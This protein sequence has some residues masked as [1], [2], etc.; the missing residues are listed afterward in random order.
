MPT[1]TEWGKKLEFWKKLCIIQMKQSLRPITHKFC[2]GMFDDIGIVWYH[3]LLSQRYN[4]PRHS[5]RKH[6]KYDQFE[7]D[8]KIEND[9]NDEFAPF[10]NENEFRQKYRMSRDSLSKL[11]DLI[12]E[13][14]AFNPCS[15]TRG[16]TDPKHQLM[17]LLV[18]L[19][20]EG[21]GASNPGLRS[22]F[23]KGRGTF[24]NFKKRCVDAILDCLGNQYLNWPIEGERKEISKRFRQ[25]F[26][27][28]NCVGVVD[29]TLLPLAFTPETDD[30]P[31]YHG[32]KYQYSL[33]VLVI[34]DDKRRI[35]YFLAGWP[36]KTHD[37]RVLR[38][39]RV[40]K[41]PSAF[42]RPNE[43]ILGDSAFECKWYCI[44]AF[45]KTAGFQIEQHKSRFN[46]LLSSPRV[47]SEHT[48]GIW[49]GRFPW[50]RSIRM[51]ITDDRKS[52]IQLLKVIK[53]T[54]ILH[55]FLIE[56]NEVFE[57]SWYDLDSI[58]DI[59][60]AEEENCVDELN[61]PAGHESK[62]RRE[63]LLNYFNEKNLL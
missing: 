19:S 5:Y 49:K 46:D 45:K 58:S 1:P 54:V 27:W 39:S 12:R 53:V 32:R 38:N 31:D 59:D 21:S 34:N 33:S 47:I 16:Q 63:Q 20:T 10:L 13:H 43:Y 40:G 26:G 62:L 3:H 24:E 11:A 14:K 25:E 37:N 2:L 15:K 52:I 36:G 51:R 22:I 42:F 48:I 57:D 61:Q 44:P 7:M 23:K 17:C 18:Y 30:A 6:D 4:N 50:L 29:G 9:A 35:R 60:E 55:N 28:P 8:L 56:E 41:N